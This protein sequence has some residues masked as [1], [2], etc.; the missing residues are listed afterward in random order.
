[1]RELSLFTGA[2]GGVLG[3]LL[4]GHQ[5]I[6]A[7][8]IDEYC[9]R[10]LAQRQ[11]DGILD[12]FPIFTD[13]RLFISSGC[14]KLYRGVTDIVTAGFPCQPWS[15]AGKREGESDNRNLFL[16]SINNAIGTFCFWLFR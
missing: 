11:R 12:K 14:A 3:S 2:G 6:G 7:V 10:V 16:T 13:I 15:L 4:L 9:Q 1:M 5:I 8:E